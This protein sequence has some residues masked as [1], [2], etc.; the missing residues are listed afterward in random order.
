M[1][2]EIKKEEIVDI[3]GDVIIVKEKIKKELNADLYEEV[4]GMFNKLLKQL[5][6]LD[7]AFQ[8]EHKW[9][10]EK[11]KQLSEE[12][13]EKYEI[14]RQKE[15]WKQYYDEVCLKYAKLEIELDIAKQKVKVLEEKGE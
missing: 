1:E 12:T 13:R 6:S 5:N 4:S 14:Q 7:R 3:E 10:D 2:E 11:N 15:K 8:N 9:L